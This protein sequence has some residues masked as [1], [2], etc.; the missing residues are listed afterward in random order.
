MFSSVRTSILSFIVFAL[1]IVQYGSL[2]HAVEHPF[3]THESEHVAHFD[4]A[5]DTHLHEPIHH[6]ANTG[7]NCDVFF[8][9]E[10]LAHVVLLIPPP[11]TLKASSTQYTV[12]QRPSVQQRHVLRPR[13]RSPPVFLA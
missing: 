12:V 9:G 11:V 10:R 13:S 6:D 4:F 3:H 1:L 7:I 2:L 8:A 5:D